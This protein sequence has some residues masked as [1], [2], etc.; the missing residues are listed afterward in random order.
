MCVVEYF[1]SIITIYKNAPGRSIGTH[2]HTAAQCKLYDYATNWIEI[3]IIVYTEYVT[4]ILLGILY[5]YTSAIHAGA[6][7]HNPQPTHGMYGCIYTLSIARL[8]M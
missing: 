5:I 1:I 4:A 7:A 6:I 3:Y 2:G 8:P